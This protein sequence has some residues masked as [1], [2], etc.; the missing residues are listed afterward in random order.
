MPIRVFTARIKWFIIAALVLAI[1]GVYWQVSHHEFI[2]FDDPSYITENSHV[3][4]GLSPANI[5]WAFSTTHAYNW[6][7]LT[8]ISHMLDCQ[9]FGLKAGCHHLVNVFLHCLNAVLLFLIFHRMTQ[10]IWQSAFVAALFALHPLHVE[11][12]AW[13][14]E[15][16]DVLSTLFWMLTMGAYVF[17]VE[18]PNTKR[19]LITLAF[20]ALGLLAKPMLVTLPFVLLLLDY[21]PLGRL[22]SSRNAENVRLRKL[23]LQGNPQTL[24]KSGP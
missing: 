12:V 1:L 18:H 20:F 4:T 3:N 24:I 10:A 6:H 8:W 13:A 23:L 2:L 17:Y 21:W 16:K 15:R 14:A 11:S 19:Y 9:L 5:G 22:E 7:P